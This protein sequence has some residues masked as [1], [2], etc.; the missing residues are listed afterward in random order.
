MSGENIKNN[1]NEAPEQELSEILRVRREKLEELRAAGR[2]PFEI[3][4][5]KRSAWTSEIRD[6]YEEYENKHVAVAGRIMSK[7]GMGKAIFCHIKDD[8]GQLQLYVRSDAVSEQEFKDFRRYDIGDIIG[9]EG[10]VFKTKTG[11]I[12]VHAEKVTLLAKSLRPL[13][14][15]FHGM[16]NVELKYRQ[17]Y[18]DLIMSDESRRNFEIRSKFVSYVRRFL[19]GR[20]Y[21]EVETPVLNT[22]SG[23]ATARP[24]ITHHNTLDMDMYLRIATELPLKRLIV[25]GI[26]RVYELGRIFRN[27]GMD[28]RHN[29]EFTTVEL[30]QAY[31]DF[32]DMMDLFEDLLSGAAMEILGTYE[33]DWQGEH[34]SLAPGWPRMTMAE[35]VNKYLGVDFM[36]ID[37]DAEAVAAAKAAG[38]DMDGKEPTWGN[39]LYECFDQKVEEH[40]VQPTFITMHPVDVSPL[41]KRSP[42]DKRLT[43]RFELFICRS[44]MG[45][46]FSE[47][48]DPIDQKERFLKQ[49]EL[50]AKGDDE[51]GMMDYDYINALEYGMPP[52]GGLG[53][54]IDRCAMLLTGSD[55]IRDVIL[56]PTMKPLDI[57]KN[58]T[59]AV[60]E[61]M[62]QL[63]EVL[64]ATLKGMP[65][66]KLGDT[67]FSKVAVE[68]LFADFVDFETFSRS[69]FRV[70]KV[71][72]CEAVKKSKKLL[73]FVL[74]DGSGED[75]VIL[76][77]IH[78]Y[79]EP[80]TLVGKTLLA[81]TNLPPRKMMGID[82]CGMIISALHKEE[83]EERLNLIIL[84]DNIPAGAKLY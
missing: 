23:G 16:T 7:R 78:D 22:I 74:D 12:S 3:T 31:A 72:A 18:V 27:E 14:E 62:D 41:A 6:G 26:E 59:A 82:S 60:S 25:G 52:T 19:E 69:D 55:S 45:N 68:P 11:E 80:E 53:I 37:S 57:Q 8:R 1:V 56:F 64:T 47:L 63:S 28:T 77:G 51:A 38:V 2:D 79:Y 36:A 61:T 43:E 49:V 40:M 33:V 9:V 29:P 58:D 30:Y 75:R 15:K 67:D 42:K 4:S 71:K 32:N 17:R 73:K 81:I 35:A 20:G 48:N 10:Y 66:N 46:A 70:V 24:F 34:V 54:G 50:R 5:F 44:E 39:A 13:P 21:M 83:G 65:V 76:S 84:D